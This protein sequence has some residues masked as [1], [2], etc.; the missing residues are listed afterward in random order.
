MACGLLAVLALTAGKPSAPVNVSADQ[1]VGIVVDTAHPIGRISPL[2]YGM[3]SPSAEHY[4]QLRVPLARWGGNPATRYNWE[5]GNSWNSARDWKF[6]NGNYGILSNQPSGSADNN[7]RIARAN[8]AQ[9]LLTL[10]T[11]GWVARDSDNRH[12][13]IHVPPRGGPPISPDSEA[14]AGY[15]PAQNRRKVSIRSLPRKSR[16]FADPPD[17]TDAAVYQDEW[18]AHLK[19][20]FGGAAAGG[21]RYYAMDNEPDLWDITHTDMHPVQPDYEELLRQFLNMAE[22]VKDADP[23]AQITGPVSWGWTGYFY[24]PRDRGTDNY[25]RHAD[26]R[27][28]GQPGICTLVFAATGA[29]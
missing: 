27:E 3:A 21:I 7:V 12:N 6:T 16:P 25:A 14:I 19:R 13:S 24:S 23:D 18:V 15:D 22:A 10:P 8:G 11:M 17:L 26:R 29:A 5:R 28:H 1:E 20:T 9:F 2:I 4:K